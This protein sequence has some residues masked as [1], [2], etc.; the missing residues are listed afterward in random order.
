MNIKGIYQGTRVS[1]VKPGYYIKVDT[2]L[3]SK[4][5]LEV[6]SSYEGNILMNKLYYLSD[7]KGNLIREKLIDKNRVKLLDIIV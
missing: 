2:G 5:K 1:I 4:K 6:F 7:L 3:I